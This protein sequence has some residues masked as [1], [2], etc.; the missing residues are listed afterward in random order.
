MSI[1]REIGRIYTFWNLYVIQP[2]TKKGNGQNMIITMLNENK[3]L[4]T[5]IVYQLQF[6]NTTNSMIFISWSPS[7]LRSLNY[8]IDMHTA[9]AYTHAYM[10]ILL[11]Q[12]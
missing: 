11:M 4:S 2:S 10:V 9:S 8:T 7:S 1:S 5:I 3:Q 12:I 6:R